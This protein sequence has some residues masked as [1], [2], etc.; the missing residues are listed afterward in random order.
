M[1]PCA[2]LVRFGTTGTEANQTAFRIA[3]AATGR[4]KIVAFEGHY[5]GW[6]DNVAWSSAQL[7]GELGAFSKGQDLNAIASLELLPWNDADSVV[8]RLSTRDVAAVIME[9]SMCNTSAIP[10]RPGYLE[11]VREACTAN[12]TV[13]IFDEVITGFRLAPGGAQEYFGVTPDLA[14]F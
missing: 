5:H 13:L 9:P 12:G 6:L 14:T 3:R 4:T 11:A 1:V 7:Y 2:D 10:P 8:D